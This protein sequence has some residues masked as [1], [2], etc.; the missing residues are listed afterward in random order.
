MTIQ[1][2]LSISDIS[3]RIEKLSVNNLKTDFVEKCKKN[4]D[5]STHAVHDLSKRPKKEKRVKKIDPV[6][7]EVRTT[8][9]VQ[10]VN[11]IAL[12]IQKIIIERAVAFLFGNPAKVSASGD[13][14]NIE[15]INGSF[16]KIGDDNKI[17]SVNSLIA[18][19]LFSSTQVAEYWYKI[20]ADKEDRYGFESTA[21]FRCQIFSPLK[22]DMLYPYFDE[23]GDMVAFSRGFVL[24]EGD[25]DVE[26]FESWIDNGNK[27]ISHTRYKKGEQG[28]EDAGFKDDI[29]IGKLPIVF[30]EQSHVEYYFV[31][32]IIERLETITSNNGDI[33]DRHASPILAAWGE[34]KTDIGDFV[35]L[36]DTGSQ[37]ADIKYIERPGNAEAIN[38]EQERMEQM[39]LKYSQTPDISFENMIG[40]VSEG[41]MQIMFIDAHMKAK[42]KF[43]QVFDSYLTRRYNILKEFLA[44][45]NPA[46][47]NDLAKTK[48]GIS[49]TPYMVGGENATIQTLVA[50]YSAGI[51]SLERVIELNPQVDNVKDELARLN[52]A[53]QAQAK[54]NV[55]EEAE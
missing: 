18:D 1:E 9:E 36:T 10:D 32:S 34:V 42:K 22:G 16:K 24:S 51:T 23:R 19:V 44:I 43:M 27:K 3:E 29:K 55:F 41:T 20:D 35:Q 15:A 53:Q 33:N 25:N 46:W 45:A 54:N 49:I 52:E 4:I 26:Y 8:T 48:V 37:K 11:R 7:K 5:P 28:W 17:D 21:K 31:Q 47:I 14:A 39:A 6:T 2:I 50:A 13:T 12:P 38:K 30:G 40:Q